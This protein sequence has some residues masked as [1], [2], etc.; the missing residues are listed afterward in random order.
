[1]VA[2]ADLALMRSTLARW[3]AASIGFRRIARTYSH[4]ARLNAAGIG[5]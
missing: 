4:A 1:L 5:D 2:R 3:R